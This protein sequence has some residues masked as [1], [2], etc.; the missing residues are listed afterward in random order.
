MSSVIK[1]LYLGY[2]W[3]RSLTDINLALKYLIEGLSHNAS[4]KQLILSNNSISAKHV[5]YLV[6]LLAFCKNVQVLSFSSNNITKGFFLISAALKY[7]AS[8]RRLFLESCSICDKQLLELGRAIQFV[9]P[10]QVLALNA[11]P[12][13]STGFSNFLK[14]LLPATLHE[15]Q[16]TLSEAMAV[17]SPLPTHLSVDFT[18]T[19]EHKQL[20]EHINRSRRRNIE[21]LMILS[22]TFHEE[23]K[24]IEKSDYELTV[25]NF[26]ELREMAPAR[27]AATVARTVSTDLLHGSNSSER[28]YSSI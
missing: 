18:L 19:K 28:L 3:H 16:I 23:E 4:C 20:V 21:K 6:L 25:A 13:T 22:G 14:C 17:L 24:N 12:F 27:K 2:N 7:L 15:G 11:N 5:Y 8:T 9:T 10:L 1:V 26:N